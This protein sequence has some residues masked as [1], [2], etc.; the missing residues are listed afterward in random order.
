MSILQ[1]II[2]FLYLTGAIEVMEDSPLW[3]CRIMGNMI[4]G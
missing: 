3:D 4:C 2:G 1:F